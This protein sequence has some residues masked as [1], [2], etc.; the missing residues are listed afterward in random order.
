[1]VK[2]PRDKKEGLWVLCLQ[3]ACNRV[4]NIT[5]C[6][7]VSRGGNIRSYRD[8]MQELPQ[9]VIWPYANG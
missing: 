8:N 7:S 4:K 2:I 9:Q 6:I 3:P 1:M 5:G